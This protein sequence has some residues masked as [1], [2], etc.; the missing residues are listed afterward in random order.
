ME[1]LSAYSDRFIDWIFVYG[2]KII[3]AIVVFVL[4]LV[5]HQLAYPSGNAG[6]E[7]TTS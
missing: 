4:G 6:H 7:P 5:R 1:Q 2:P 3:G